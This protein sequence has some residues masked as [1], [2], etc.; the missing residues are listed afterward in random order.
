MAVSSGKSFCSRH[1]SKF[2]T[3]TNITFKNKVQIN[4]QGIISR[5][6]CWIAIDLVS[7]TISAI[8]IDQI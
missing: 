5:L 3:T 4:Y 1:V 2:S 8:D 7:G 6:H